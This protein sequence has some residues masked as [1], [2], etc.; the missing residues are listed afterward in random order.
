MSPK[1]NLGGRPAIDD[2]DTVRSVTVTLKMSP[3]ERALLDRLIAAR[4]AEERASTAGARV[5]V[6]VSSLVR[7]LL[8]R[9]AKARGLGRGLLPPFQG[10]R[11]IAK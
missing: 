11:P 7:E 2:R 4:A 8:H 6:T 10:G 1:R 9:E 3:A 5:E